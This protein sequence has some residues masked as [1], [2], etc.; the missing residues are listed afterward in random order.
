MF[1]HQ[2][3]LSAFALIVFFIF[4]GISAFAQT[5]P[6]SAQPVISGVVATGI[7]GSSAIIS[8]TTDVPATSRIDYGATTNYEV[9]SIIDSGLRTSHQISLSPLDTNTTYHYRVRSTNASGRERV[10]VDNTFTTNS[11]LDYIPP[12]EIVSLRVSTATVTSLTITWIEPGD[13]GSAGTSTSYE[14]RASS[15]LIPDVGALSWWNNATVWS[16]AP[17]P[18]GRK[19]IS[20]QVF[21]KGTNFLKIKCRKR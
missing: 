14:I 19:R 18:H 11:P 7:T 3:T 12:D 8:W 13:N 21:L 6:D 16:G 10:D 17:A 20:F 5:S 4:S 2:R 1:T 15:T 9:P